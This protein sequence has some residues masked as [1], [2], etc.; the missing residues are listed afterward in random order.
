MYK[1]DVF[2]EWL[3]GLLEDFDEYLERLLDE[4]LAESKLIC[5]LLIYACKVN[6]FYIKYRLNSKLT[7]IS[8]II[9]DLSKT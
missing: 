2:D 7:A 5:I 9:Q 6:N 8:F 1:F 3:D 4:V